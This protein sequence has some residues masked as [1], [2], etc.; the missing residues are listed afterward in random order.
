MAGNPYDVIVVGARCAGSATAMLLARQG[1]RVLLVDRATFPSD[2]VS[3]HLIH[4]PGVAALRR[5][6]LL[7]RVLATGCPPIDTYAFDFGPFTLTGSPGVGDLRFALAP[8]RTV[9]D[10]VLLDAAAEAGA[11]VRQGFSVDGLVDE[12]G[13]VA[14]IRGHGRGGPAVTERAR[15]VVGAD[16]WRSVVAD[17]VSAPRYHEK[18]RL[19][20]LYYSYW[21][22]LAMSGRFETYVRPGRGFAAW[23]TNDDL[24]VVIVGWPQAEFESNRTDVEGNVAKT[25][26]LSPAFADRVEAGSRVERFV[27]MVTPNF[28][29]RPWGPGWALVGDAGYVKDPITGQG[30]QDAF[31]DA[32]LC[33]AALHDAFGGRRSYDEAMAALQHTRD[34]ESLPMYELTCELALLEPP[35]PELAALLTAVAGDQAAMDDFARLN[36]GVLSPTEFFAPDNVARILRRAAPGSGG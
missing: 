36:A 16:G 27:G 34:V 15:V 23:P 20:A 21:S 4:P 28:L 11:E 30:I 24:T 35:A 25:L 29:R 33:A 5:W 6:G 8:R 12:D 31:R 22:G 32:Q 7:D 19:L 17:A 1:H 10:M 9:L 13:R 26:A 2:T 18:P 14:G 3:T